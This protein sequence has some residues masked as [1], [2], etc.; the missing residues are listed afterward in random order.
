MAMGVESKECPF[1]PTDDQC[2]NDHCA[3]KNPKID[4]EKVDEQEIDTERTDKNLQE[5]D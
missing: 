3:W 2:K 5:R 1:C 4:T